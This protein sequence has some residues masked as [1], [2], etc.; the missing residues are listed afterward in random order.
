[1]AAFLGP[2][3]RINGSV[4]GLVLD[5]GS[6]QGRLPLPLLTAEFETGSNCALSK[7]E[8]QCEKRAF[9]THFASIQTQFL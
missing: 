9:R 6:K 8:D 1:M 7:Q 2:Q 4:T 3:T 5:L